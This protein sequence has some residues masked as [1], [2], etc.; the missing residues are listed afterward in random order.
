MVYTQLEFLYQ[1]KIVRFVNT[2]RVFLKV[3]LGFQKIRKKDLVKAE[4][5]YQKK[6]K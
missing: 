6:E 1:K 5:G 4:K 2:C 3:I